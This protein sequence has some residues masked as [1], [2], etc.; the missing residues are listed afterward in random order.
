MLKVVDTFSSSYIRAGIIINFINRTWRDSHHSQTLTSDFC[1]LR[2]KKKNFIFSQWTAKIAQS[3]LI[4]YENSGSCARRRNRDVSTRAKMFIIQS[5]FD[6]H[7]I[8]SKKIYTNM[9]HSW[10]MLHHHWISLTHFFLTKIFDW[11]FSYDLPS[12]L[13]FDKV[14]FYFIFLPPHQKLLH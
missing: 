2:S 14:D 1:L 3:K 9:R 12:L 8:Y 7:K 13:L 5:F 4:D 11:N 10:I 6:L